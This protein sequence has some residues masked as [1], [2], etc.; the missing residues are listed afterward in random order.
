MSTVQ[1]YER[2]ERIRDYLSLVH[3]IA[4]R[5]SYKSGCDCDDLIQVGCLGLIQASQRFSQIQADSF[6]VFAKLHIRGAILHYLRDKTSLVRLPRQVEERA[7]KLRNKSEHVLSPDDQIIQQQYKYKTKW[8][9]L[10]EECLQDHKFC[11]KTIEMSEQY[12]HIQLALKTLTQDEQ[13]IVRLVV[14]EGASLRTA[15]KNLGVSA[16]TIQRRLKRA[17]ARLRD[18]LKSDQSA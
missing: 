18:L 8:V 3:P 1:F 17:L 5:Y 11:W 2:N 15:G 7:L 4:K 12:A 9:E 16:M 13:D 14:V 6:S 10:N